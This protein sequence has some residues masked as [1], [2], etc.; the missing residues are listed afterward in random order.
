M[1]FIVTVD[2]KFV[3]SLSVV[4]VGT[5][6]AVKMDSSAAERVSIHVADACKEYAF[7]VNSE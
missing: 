4:T 5:I 6:F 2:W 3:V 7:A 1:N